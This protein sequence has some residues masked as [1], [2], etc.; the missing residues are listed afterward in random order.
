MLQK[1]CFT[2]LVCLA[3]GVF[4]DE[5]FSYDGY[6]LIRLTPQSQSHIGSLKKWQNNPEF[7]LWGKIKGVN[8]AVD[9]LLSPEHKTL[10][11]QLFKDAKIPF[12]T[13]VENIR[14]NIEEQDES[15]KRSIGDRSI[16]GKFARYS[17]IQSFIADTVRNNPGF[18]SSYITG[19]TYEN[20]DLNVIV[21]GAS[22][23][24]R[25]IWMDCGIHAREWISPASCIYMIDKFLSE[26]KSGNAETVA[27]LDHYE[28][29]IL[30]LMN[31]DG[32]EYS[33]NSYRY[34]R[35]NRKPNAG[36]SCIGTDLNRN[37]GYM[38]MTG[39][40]SNNPCSDIFAG[41]GASS[42]AEI[43]GV[44]RALNS[45]L[46]NWDAYLTFHTYGQWIFTPWGYASVVPDDY[47]ELLRVGNIGADAIRRESGNSWEV[48]SSVAILGG[49]G[50]GGS[51]DWAKGVAGIKYAYCF[52]LR[53]AQYGTDSYYGFALP[54]SRIPAAGE[55]TFKGIKAMLLAI[56]A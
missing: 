19:Q 18:V 7:D 54:A 27:L 4:A 50:S 28:I 39:G 46:G 35:K 51:E 1:I 42:E 40:S 6:S 47:N 38:W 22:E 53:P 26:Y 31:P 56:K 12:F 15:M 21:L 23:G 32:Y 8:V 24:K 5:K 36:S 16:V 30:P 45:K 9:V 10:Y 55:E 29:H 20:R 49:A 25:S 33:H 14:N 44:Q 48:G 41:P 3:A 34:W 17:E 37:S 43:K 2:L 13:A 11:T 52:E